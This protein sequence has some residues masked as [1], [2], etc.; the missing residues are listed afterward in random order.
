MNNSNRKELEGEYIFLAKILEAGL[1][2][3]KFLAE[4][5]FLDSVRTFSLGQFLRL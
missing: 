5:V 2:G 3:L 4:I 1:G